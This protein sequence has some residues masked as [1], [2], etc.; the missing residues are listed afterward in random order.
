MWPVAGPVISAYRNGDDPYAGG[1]HRGVDI[2]AATGT[3]V[4]AA[5]SGNVAFAGRVPGGGTTV[6]IRTSDSRLLLS[7]LYLASA[8]VRA[9]D[10]VVA[11]A[12]IGKVGRAGRHGAG[13]A[14]LHFGVRDLAGGKHA[15]LD[16]LKM[17]PP[18][19]P[20]AEPALPEPAPIPVVDPVEVPV[21]APVAADPAPVAGTAPA[22]R[23]AAR[24]RAARRR[25]RLVSP[26]PRG[27]TLFEPTGVPLAD[28][29]RSRARRRTAAHRPH[30]RSIYDTLNAPTPTRRRSD[31]T[32][33]PA[34]A[35]R[36]TPR[37]TTTPAG[38][39]PAI[40]PAA[41]SAPAPAPAP[42]LPGGT[43]AANTRRAQGGG[44]SDLWLLAAICA[45]A[46]IIPSGRALTRRVDT[47]R[48]WFG[49]A[50][51][52]DARHGNDRPR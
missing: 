50:A 36:S 40:N 49:P 44:S 34:Q 35:R 22:R 21:T 9:G 5:T 32:V 12:P 10:R 7:Y 37:R 1:M 20:P 2:A 42:G 19:A 52:G 39:A 47:L 23:R 45:A 16:P 51:T 15:Y 31:A 18:V 46:A 25:A 4:V 6:S 33:A 24:R 8:T 11:G 41:V 26:S 27:V 29:P 30:A 3:P 28:T 13:R 48:E 17:L 38:V 14:L 43:G